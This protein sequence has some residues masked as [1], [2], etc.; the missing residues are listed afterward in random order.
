VWGGDCGCVA[1]ALGGVGVG[2]CGAEV[3]AVDLE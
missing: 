2:V 3:G 1:D